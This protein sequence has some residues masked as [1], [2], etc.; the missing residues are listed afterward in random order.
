MISLEAPW[1][2]W[3]GMTTINRDGVAFLGGIALGIVKKFKAWNFP[4]IIL[5]K[6]QYT[7]GRRTFL[8]NNLCS[9]VK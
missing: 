9:D 8:H 7:N 6:F 2:Y 1:Y 4:T 5:Y 3:L